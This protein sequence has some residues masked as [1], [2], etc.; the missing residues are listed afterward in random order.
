LLS[1]KTL[2][3][4]IVLGGFGSS[5]PS[6]TEVLTFQVN[7]DKQPTISDVLRY[8]KFPEIHHIFRDDAR[9]PP[10]ILTLVFTL[11]VVAALPVLLGSWLFLGA[12]LSQLPKAFASAPISHTLFF[13]SIVAMEG[14]FYLYYTSWNLGQLLPAAGVV[15]LVTFL[16]ASGALTEVQERRLKGER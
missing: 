13:G 7:S 9:S 10:K 15:G 6:N 11:A 3:A 16:S 4:S 8:G 14:L 5:K 12:N 1:S 2:H